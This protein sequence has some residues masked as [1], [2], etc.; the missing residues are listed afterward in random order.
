VPFFNKTIIGEWLST[1]CTKGSKFL[2]K[3]K[4]SL[5]GKFT[6]VPFFRK[7]LYRS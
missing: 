6:F 5:S 7:P 3:S 4:S 1:K 2:A